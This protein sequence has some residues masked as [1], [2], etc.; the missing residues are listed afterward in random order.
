MSF[1]A[2]D[3]TVAMEEHGW[4]EL[5]YEDDGYPFALL[6]DGRAVLAH[7]VA[8]SKLG[9]GATDVWIVIEI[10]LRYF[11]KTGYHQ[12]HSGTYWDGSVTEV[13]PVRE[14]ITVYDKI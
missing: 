8:N 3:V 9:E 14:V 6:L 4:S 5:G 7:K 11:K 13:R 2:N 1:D 12:S 10:G